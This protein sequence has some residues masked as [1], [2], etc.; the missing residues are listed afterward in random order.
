MTTAQLQ[1]KATIEQFLREVI[2]PSKGRIVAVLEKFG[3]Y[4]AATPEVIIRTYQQYGNEFLQHFYNVYL[5][6]YQIARMD[7]ANTDG[8]LK[9]DKEGKGFDYM[10]ISNIMDSAAN[11]WGSLFGGGGNSAGSGTPPTASAP[12]P[13]P[14]PSKLSF[15]NPLVIAG[16]VIVFLIVLL[17][18]VKAINKK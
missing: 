15:T 8:G 17:V 4:D 7:G 12:A 11:L 14:A 13:A 2:E 3:V 6:S 9:D 5:S 16:G 1:E 10:Q 18:V